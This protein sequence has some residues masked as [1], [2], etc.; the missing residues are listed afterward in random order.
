MLQIASYGGGTNSTAMLI[1]LAER[2]EAVHLILFA[3]PGAEMPHTYIYLDLFSGWL[4]SKGQ[5]PIVTVK[6]PNK[7]LEQDCLDRFA[8]PAIAYG[9]KTCSQRWKMEPQEKYLNNWQPAKEVWNHGEKITRLIGYDADEPQRAKAYED[10]K[11]TNRYPLI[12][13]GWGRDECID[14]INR[15]GLPQP[16]KSSCFFCPSMK[17]AEII[18]LKKAYPELAQR[19]V[20]LER[21]ADLSS[22]KGLGRRFSWGSLITADDAQ[23]KMFPDLEP[24]MPC[25]CYDG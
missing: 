4:V 15:A 24:D 1:G 5:G 19:A 9:F 2:G 23:Y 20:E 8:L 13:W 12:E 11:Y 3:D 25:G 6:A 10:K 21:N 16:G 7:S 22:I 14:A 17:K 18:Q